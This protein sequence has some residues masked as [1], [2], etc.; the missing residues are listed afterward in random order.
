[1]IRAPRAV[2]A[3][4]YAPRRGEV[5]GRPVE[6]MRGTVARWHVSIHRSLRWPTSDTL[7]GTASDARIMARLE[8]RYGDMA[9]SRLTCPVIPSGDGRRAGTAPLGRAGASLSGA[10][11]TA[12]G[13]CSWW[14]QVSRRGARAPMSETKWLWMMARAMPASPPSVTCRQSPARSGSLR[15]LPSGLS[16]L[17]GRHG[18]WGAATFSVCAGRI[19]DRTP[20]GLEAFE[21]KPHRHRAFSNGGRGPFD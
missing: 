13:S 15:L 17:A 21:D 3:L 5:H 20:G 7:R 8:R 19:G 6:V 18:Q 1:M 10:V 9:Q 12:V 11:R 16:C 4:A 2:A 14:R